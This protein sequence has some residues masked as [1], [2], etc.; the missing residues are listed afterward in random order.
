MYFILYIMLCILIDVN[1]HLW[2]PGGI[3]PS[4]RR[5][6]PTSAPSAPP[7]RWAV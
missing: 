2:D 7:A 4:R 1:H 5:P 6:S 3:H